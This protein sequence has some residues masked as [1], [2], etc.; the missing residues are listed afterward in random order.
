MRGPHLEGSAVSKGQMKSCALSCLES[1]LQTQEI[2]KFCPIL[3]SNRAPIGDNKLGDFCVFPYIFN[4]FYGIFGV[5]VIP[6][7]LINDS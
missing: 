4:V 6:K 1:R 3:G 7:W 5:H 2:P